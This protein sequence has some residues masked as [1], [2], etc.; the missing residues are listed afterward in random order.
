M[1]NKS[2]HNFTLIHKLG[3]GG[4]AE[5][6]YAENSIG[7]KAAVK[8]LKDEFTKMET[9][10]HRFK[11]EAKVMVKLSHPNIRQVYD[12]GTIDNRPCIVM[13]YLEG[14]DLS[15]R[16]KK[17]ECF[18]DTQLQQWWNAIVDTL[19]YTHAQGVVHRDIKPSNIFITTQGEL[20]LLD[21]GI[22]KIKS[23][24]TLTQTGNR[25]GTLMYMSPEQVKDS[26]HLDYRSDL[27]SLAVTFYH[28]VTGTAPYDNTNS[29]EFDI[30]LKIVTE[31]LDLSVLPPHWR[32]LLT[33]LLS[34]V[35]SERGELVKFGEQIA[36]NADE[37]IIESI[38][39][40]PR[41]KLE[42]TPQPKPKSESTP[43]QSTPTKSKTGLWIGLVILLL[44]VVGVVFWQITHN[45]TFDTSSTNKHTSTSFTTYTETVNG[46]S[47]KMV[48]IPGGSFDMGSNEGDSDEKPVHRV[49][50][51]QFYMGETEVTQALWEAVMGS[52]PSYF[53][54]DNNPVENVSWD[55]CQV[56][57][58]KLNALTGKAYRLPSEAEWEYACRAATA[59]A[60]N[61]GDN[62]TTSQANYNGNY[63][64]KNYSEGVYREKTTPVKTFSAN[65][66]GL[67]DMHGNV[68]EWCEDRWHAN[69]T[70]APT[71]GSAWVSGSSS[72]RVLRGGSWNGN[73]KNCRSAYRIS[74][75]SGNRHIN[76]GFRVVAEY[77]L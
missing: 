57:I 58:T 56:F 72:N 1:Q 19:A 60:F 74:I 28:L 50:V 5:V 53:K 65:A 16:L 73:A 25:M 30:Q 37:T 41:P 27:Y 61:T 31:T 43:K 13:E 67:Y 12:Y 51:P 47:F 40:T 10:L 76:Y 68:W 14:A 18:Y 55:D 22:A 39:P 70:G 52:N 54:G 64:Y 4:M 11:N 32:T 15:D 29:S 36:I 3:E 35:P 9:V 69:Y 49:T 33:P 2:I 38:P 7:R 66:Y 63:P 77:G 26:K 59:T 6:W 42:P 48:T 17:D 62:L 71:D 44:S 23:S 8:I 20:K 75:S 24:I 45:R 21:F 34:K 46:V